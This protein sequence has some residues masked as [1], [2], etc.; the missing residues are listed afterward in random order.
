MVLRCQKR[1]NLDFLR[2]LEQV[3]VRSFVSRGL[4]LEL[5]AGIG[6]ALAL[7]ALAF[8]A[9]NTRGVATQ[10]SLTAETRDQGGRT[11]VALSVTVA[12]QD[13][14]P[15]TGAVVISDQGRQIAGVALDAQGHAASTLDLPEG[16]HAL[17]ATYTGDAAHQ[18]S[19]SLVSP[20]RAVTGSGTP[21]FGIAASPATLSLA[22]GASGA[23]TASVTPINGASLTAPMFVTLSCAG[24]PDLATCTFTPENV[25]VQP[26]ATAAVT[27]SMVIGTSAGTITNPAASLA[28]PGSNPV[29]WAVLLPGVLGLAGLAFG[30]RRRRWLSRLSLLALVALVTVLGATACAP[31]YNYKNHGPP[32][33][34]PTPAGSYT[35]QINAQ[36]SNGITATTHSTTMVLTV[37]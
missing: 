26:N 32:H 7:P 3:H 4:R 35:I 16:D 2:D 12:G 11:Q 6:I 18:G 19:V 24:L 34:L 9:A 29:A 10:T 22:P 21:D 13:G 27:S 20:V 8:S 28:T 36:S 37:Q 14:Q 1:A 30:A 31:L 5:V 15:A 23:I 17:T 33:N 25:E